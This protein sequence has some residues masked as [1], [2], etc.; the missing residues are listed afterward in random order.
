M[1]DELTIVLRDVRGRELELTDPYL[2]KE[3]EGFAPPEVEHITTQG[4]YQ[5]GETWEDAL[6]N[7]RIINLA[8]DIVGDAGFGD[9]WSL[10]RTLIDTLAAYKYGVYVEIHQPDGEIV[11]AFGRYQGRVEAP[12]GE[13]DSPSVQRVAF[14]I[15]CH[16][17]VLYDPAQNVW[18]VTK[19]TGGSS[20][21]FP[22][23]FPAGFGAGALAD[24]ETFEYQGTIRSFPIITI[25]GPATDLVLRNESTDEKLDF[26]GYT[27]E[28]G[29]QVEIDCRYRYKTVESD[30]DGNVQDEL[31]DA[32]D[33]STF[34]IAADPE[35]GDGHNTLSVEATGV[36]VN[37]RIEVRFDTNYTGR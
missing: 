29:E 10:R 18:A 25:D 1:S 15:R 19:A 2:L 12:R 11:E 35:V 20:W 34:H 21:A 28:A 6:M 13:D 27:I 22:L 33:L 4:P 5:V 7:A 24:E 14:S 23:A 9:V 8:V 3:Y 16:N 30:A 17:S 36:T 32:S 31:T 37:T 26:T